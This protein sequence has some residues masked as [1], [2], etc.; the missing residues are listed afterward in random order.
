MRTRQAEHTQDCHQIIE[1][2]RQGVARHKECSKLATI[3]DRDGLRWLRASI[4]LHVLDL[5][6]NVIS[7]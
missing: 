6:Y 4:H 5:V 1:K 7:F 3:C 2:R